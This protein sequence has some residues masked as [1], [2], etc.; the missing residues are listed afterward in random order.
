[1]ASSR[2]TDPEPAIWRS[3]GD[4]LGHVDDAPPLALTLLLV[5]LSAAS[6]SA[7]RGRRDRHVRDDARVAGG[8]AAG[9][10]NV[11]ATPAAF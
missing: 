2:L 1:M 6:S 9:R 4:L 7:R 10:L 5:P 8:G 3:E 11:L